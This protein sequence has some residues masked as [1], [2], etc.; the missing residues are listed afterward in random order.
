MR[1]VQGMHD[2]KAAAHARDT[3]RPRPS[4]TRD[5]GRPRPSLT[6]DT[7]EDVFTAVAGYFSLLSDPTRLRILHAICDGERSVSA[8]TAVTAASQTN[9]SRHLGVLY[10]AGVVARRREGVAV[11]YRVKDRHLAD[12]CRAVCVQIAGRID[13]AEPLRR[14]LLDFAGGAS[15]ARKTGQ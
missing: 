3:G 9:V 4:L 12:L 10:R 5:T 7:L 2:G 13:A 14:E 15:T 8:I 1:R 6:R 11:L